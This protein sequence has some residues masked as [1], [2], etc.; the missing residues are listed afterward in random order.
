MTTPS[1]KRHYRAVTAVALCDG[2]DAAIV[3]VNRALRHKGFEVIYLGFH[4]SP[5]QIVRA[6]IQE[7]ADVIGISSYNGGHLEFIEDLTRVLK[8]YGKKIP[9]VIGGGGTITAEDEP[10]LVE[11]G[12]ARVYSPGMTLDAVAEDVMQ[13]CRDTQRERGTLAELGPAAVTGDNTALGECL[14]RIESGEKAPVGIR[15]STAPFVVGLCGP[16]GAGKSTLLDE[17]VMRFTAENDG[18]PAVLCSDPSNSGSRAQNDGIPGAL[19]GDRIRL[20]CSDDE[21]VFVRSLATRQHHGGIAGAVEEMLK[22]LRQGDH[23]IVFVESAGIGQSDDP[24]G[25]LVDLTI[26]VM[27]PEF[28]SQLQLEK[29]VMLELADIVVL[30]KSDQP[31][32]KAAFSQIRS[33]VRSM[34][35]DGHKAGLHLVSAASHR[36]KGVDQLYQEIMSRMQER[37]NSEAGANA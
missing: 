8:E 24:F 1:P 5:R 34:E 15:E 22:L 3:A 36:D 19:L 35:Y 20:L 18:V 11:R 33:K 27:T 31:S 28:G 10:L 13:L 26:L 16:G 12:A 7:D 29:M 4:K 37:Q 32:S 25:A 14:T 6:A 17:I 23:P 2:H 9:V 21:S 30:N